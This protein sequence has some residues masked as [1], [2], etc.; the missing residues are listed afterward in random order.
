MRIQLE[1]G[2]RREVVW[3][4]GRRLLSLGAAMV[5]MW[6]TTPA[7]GGESVDGLERR[8]MLARIDQ[9]P[10]IER[11]VTR[12]I[13][14]EPGS[15]YGHYLMSRVLMRQYAL[16][17]TESQLARQA[18]EMAQ[19]AVELDPLSDYGYVALSETLSVLGHSREA[20]ALLDK[21]EE[22]GVR[23]SWR[24]WLL[25]ADL[26]SGGGRMERAAAARSLERAAISLGADQELVAAGV[27]S[28]VNSSFERDEVVDE[29][30]RWATR[31]PHP[32]IEEALAAAMAES[33]RYADARRVYARLRESGR[34]SREAWINEGILLY[35]DLDKP[36]EAVTILSEVLKRDRV[37][38][39][40]FSE[41]MTRLNL[42]SAML[43]SLDVA[44]A[45][46]EFAR[47][48][49]LMPSADV[50]DSLAFVARAYDK[51]R[52]P[53]ELLALIEE[54]RRDMPGQ[55][56]FYAIKGETLSR[57]IGDQK[58]A[59]RAFRDAIV[60][61]PDQAEYFGGLGL[62]HYRMKQFEEAA[63]AF[64]MATRLDPDAATPRYNLACALALMGR[65]DES[66]NALAEALAIDPALQM[67][68]LGD[69]DFALLRAEVGFQQLVGVEATKTPARTPAH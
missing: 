49:R 3:R 32:A 31:R 58:A 26:L 69:S 34:Y 23:M 21:A 12:L 52:R 19:Q 27:V 55:G 33:G 61:E 64:A 29:L 63:G 40:A 5:W 65:K 47:A 22:L 8:L 37:G 44:G 45:R 36:R 14:V 18:S 68:A 50:R 56:I 1:I 46:G 67:T 62:V 7:L 13:Q 30:A 11:D 39:D 4:V 2:G 20:K 51:R 41:G 42:A 66:L 38:M 16:A 17:P 35:R 60:L 9:M 25:K 24:A 54:I 57:D 53:K 28:Y 59:I 10:S 43:G 15:A 6:L 48:L